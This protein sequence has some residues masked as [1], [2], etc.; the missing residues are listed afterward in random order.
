MV[1]G[2]VVKEVAHNEIEPSCFMLE[3]SILMFI[4]LEINST[5]KPSSSIFYRP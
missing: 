2:V 1:V 5:T 4:Y 3:D